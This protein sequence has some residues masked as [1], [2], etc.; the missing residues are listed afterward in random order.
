MQPR[1]GLDCLD[2][3]QKS[4]QKRIEAFLAFNHINPARFFCST[5]KFADARIL[6]SVISVD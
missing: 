2:Q 5:A 3:T 1:F 6:Y 4:P